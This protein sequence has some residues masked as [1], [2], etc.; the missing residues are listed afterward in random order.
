[1]NFKKQL[2][3]I[4]YSNFLVTSYYLYIYNILRI[5]LYKSNININNFTTIKVFFINKFIINLKLEK[6]YKKILLAF[7]L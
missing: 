6:Y 5:N 7:N 3:L 4:L 2:K 1:M